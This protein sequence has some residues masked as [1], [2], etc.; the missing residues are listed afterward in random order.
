[1]TFTKRQ[2]IDTQREQRR[3]TR[4]KRDSWSCRQTDLE[5]SLTCWSPHL[6]PRAG[7]ASLTQK[8]CTWKV[9][10]ARPCSAGR[11]RCALP[12]SRRS[13]AEC[14]S[15]PGHAAPPAPASHRSV[16][17]QQPAMLSASL[18]RSR[19]SAATP[20]SGTRQRRPDQISSRLPFLTCRLLQLTLQVI[21]HFRF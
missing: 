5:P 7:A 13:R 17:P 2:F 20:E 21:I 19:G 12:G 9:R 18:C 8:V 1:M 6:V 3:E 16:Q 11:P 4:T 10:A 14:L 15:A